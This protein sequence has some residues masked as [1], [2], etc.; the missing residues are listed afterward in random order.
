MNDIKSVLLILGIIILLGIFILKKKVENKSWIFTIINFKLWIILFVICYFYLNLINLHRAAHCLK[1]NNLE[2]IS[3]KINPIISK[4]HLLSKPFYEFYINTSH[5]SYLPCAQNGDVASVE[6][7]TNALK[8]GARVIELDVFPKNNVG[9]SYGDFEPVVAHG[10]ELDSGNIFTTSYVYFSDCVKAISKFSITTSDPIWIDIELNT[11]LNP[12][13]QKRIRE[14]ILENFSKKLLS[15][16]YKI[17]NK[18]K[19][20]S[21][22]PI[23]NLLNKII[24]TTSKDTNSITDN[25]LDIFDGY[26]RDGFYLN[27]SADL[28]QINKTKYQIQRIYPPGDIRG[29]FSLN[30][31][32]T[33]FWKN[34]VQ[35]VALNFQNPDKY[36]NKNIKMFKN[37]SF[38]HFSE[39]K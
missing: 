21:Q 17:A 39:V 13:T 5:N 33:I 37:S 35:L 6:A 8:M 32:P 24:I 34:F 22:E 12:I 3:K 15:S 27:S 11:N 38:I 28:S 10:L 18:I 25:L 1:L 36:L 9:K 29:H 19:H 26:A 14:I 7:I 20:F 16:K 4:P 30:Y 2:I 31:D 23:V